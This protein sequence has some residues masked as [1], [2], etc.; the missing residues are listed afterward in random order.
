[1]DYIMRPFQETKKVRLEDPVR[2]GYVCFSSEDQTSLG[3]GISE[4]PVGSSNQNHVHENA[5]EVIHILAGTFKFVFPD[6]EAVMRPRD[7][8]YIPRGTWHQIFNIGDTPAWH[9]FVFTDTKSV[10]LILNH[11]QDE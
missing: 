4:V 11:Y 8:I 3:A 5:D 6:S 2:Y 7:C 1:M 9:T 10:D